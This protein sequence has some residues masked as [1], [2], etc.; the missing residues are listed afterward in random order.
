MNIRKV[1]LGVVLC[2]AIAYTPLPKLRFGNLKTNMSEENASILSEGEI[3]AVEEIIDSIKQP[4]YDIAFESKIIKMNEEKEVASRGET[5]SIPNRDTSMK[6]Y[7][8]YKA[9][10]A[11]NTV[12]WQL[13]QR[14]DVYT[15]SE[16][17]RRIGDDFMVAVGSYYGQVGDKLHITLD[18]GEFTAVIADQKKNIHTDSENKY[19]ISDGSVLEFLIGD[20]LLPIIKKMGDCS[21]SSENNFR[22]NVISIENLGSIL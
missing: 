19:H 2:I 17:F 4:K 5:R 11:K 18:N 7:M 1:T 9:I 10:T 22:G 16:G 13:Q 12:Q 15:D 20:G 8:S 3:L 6:T 21:Y 14:D